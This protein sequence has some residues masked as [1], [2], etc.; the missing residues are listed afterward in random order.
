MSSDW[1]VLT[2][3]DVCEKITDGAHNSP[4]SV[5]NG[6]P[7]ASV[8]DLT[9]FGVELSEARLISHEDFDALVKQGCRPEVGDVLIAK[10][11]N[12]AL[13]T[14]CTV[15][16]PLDAVLLSS[17]AILRPNKE[18]LDADFLKY[19]F[20]SKETIDYLKSNFI[21]GAAIP[22]VVL[23][24]FR[25]AVIKIP[26]IEKQR[27]IS[28]ILRSLDNKIE[29]NRQTNQ[30][31]EQIAQAIFK[32]WFVDFEPVKA[33][34]AAKQAGASAEQIESAA[35]CAISGKTPE[36]LAQLDPQTLQQLKT[37][38]ALFTDALV[39]SELG[40]IPE[41]WEVKTLEKLSSTI[42]MGPFGSNIKVETFVDEGVPIINGQQLKGTIL[43]DGDNKFLTYDHAD[44]LIKSNVYRGDIEIT[45]RGTLG[46]VSIIPE[47][48]KYERYIVSQSQCYIRPDREV[49]SPLFMIYYFKFD[50]GQHELLAHKS[51]V[52]VPSI[53]MPVTNLRKIELLVPSKGILDKF[54]EIVSDL[55]RKMSKN[56]DEIYS[57]QE[58]RDTLLPRLLSGEF[59]INPELPTLQ[60]TL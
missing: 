50:V 57:L 6:K 10:D 39:D 48:S 34:M 42:A 45:H 32:S 27:E 23:K 16:K 12:S 8:K 20:C 28:R 25:K 43:E 18:K 31:L 14:V 2:L 21:S 49:I 22:R 53:A 59:S 30:T 37:T 51:Q 38:A 35:L 54:Q 40:E 9:Q 7:M 52:G 29:L 15:D 36:Q 60:E 41:G 13:D 58:L 46:Q 19:Y 24:D 5:Q 47:G 11:G 3:G 56:I 44:K 4:K 1:A 26:P 55:Q 33:K 17:V